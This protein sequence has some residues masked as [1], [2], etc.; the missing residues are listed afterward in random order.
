MSAR[1][2][3]AMVEAACADWAKSGGYI[4]FAEFLPDTKKRWLDNMRA[5]LA[6]ALSTEPG[7]AEGW[8]P[9]ET[10]SKKPMERILLAFAGGRVCEGY[11]GAS[12]YN[13]STRL[14]E[15][16]WVTS[17]HSGPVRPTYWRPLP[18]P[19]LPE[20]THHGR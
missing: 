15:Q 5:A 20:D 6:A 1:I 14:W 4:P 19:P 18:A 12:N 17:P 11:W 8:Q 3:E 2:T 10:A 13:R 9:I 16:D 7:E